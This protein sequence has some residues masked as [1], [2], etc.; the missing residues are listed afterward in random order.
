MAIRSRSA[1]LRAR[2]NVLA[3]VGLAVV[4]LLLTGPALLGA[5]ALGPEAALD[6]DPLYQRERNPPPTP[7]FS[8][9][10]AL[11]F[12]YPHDLA[13]ARGL[14]AG[15]LDQWNPLAG[16]G[17]PLWAEQTG[18][19]FPLKLVFYLWPTPR[20]YTAFLAARLLLAGFG[21]YL[22]ARRRV[23]SALPAF[24]AATLYETSGAVVAN[25]SFGASAPLD[26]L[27]WVVLAAQA[28]AGV[29]NWRAV[30]GAS[31]A[32]GL[33]GLG[34][35]PVYVLLVWGSFVVVALAETALLLRRERRQA[36]RTV[37]RIAASLALGFALAAPAL[38]PLWE[39][40]SV[41]L[42]YKDS[43]AA[44]LM[45][46]DDL[47]RNRLAAPVGWLA[48]GLVARLGADPILR[49]PWGLGPS[50]G[51]L[52][53]VL[54]LAG[55]LGGGLGVGLLALLGS[56]L[57]LAF[58]PLTLLHRLPGLALVFPRYAWPLVAL[59]MTQAA[60]SGL[61]ALVSVGRPRALFGAAASVFAATLACPY[62]RW[63]RWERCAKA[64]GTSCCRRPRRWSRSAPRWR[65]GAVGPPRGSCWRSGCW[66]PER[67]SW[68]C[69]PTA[70]TRRLPSSRNRLRRWSNFCASVWQAATGGSWLSPPM[71]RFRRPRC[72]T[73]W[74]TFD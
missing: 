33:A 67:R 64:S 55:V 74:P 46:Q 32:L 1:G 25:A 63:P 43:A 48:P 4:A 59:T 7:L 41:G 21:A 13:F 24:F 37:T 27:P 30:A 61:C 28:I 22:L 34:G 9:F 73:D 19:L 56:G 2:E 51:A 47:R 15:R 8:D 72:C 62:R 14:R 29:P 40:R 54:G 17:T 23:R 68:M 3:L 39:L 36:I 71:S 49:L 35:H 70:V 26:L 57:L 44:A 16:T 5:A 18:S 45:I 52:G 65:S 20:G 53:L 60:A 66:R 6:S 11:S 10:S 69:R 31:L 58:D 12:H 38:L 42:T 50:V